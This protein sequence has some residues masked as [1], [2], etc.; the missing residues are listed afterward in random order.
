MFG[1][2]GHD[3]YFC[4]MLL[5]VEELGDDGYITLV[6]MDMARL[7]YVADGLV[8]ADHPLLSSGCGVRFV[9][10]RLSAAVEE[11]DGGCPG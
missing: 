11:M 9:V 1:R 3:V 5:V 6:V 10:W 8:S 7:A 2:V 4:D